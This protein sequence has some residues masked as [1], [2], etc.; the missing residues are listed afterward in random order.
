M[1]FWAWTF[2][3]S[4]MYEFLDTFILCWKNVNPSFLQVYHHIGA[5]LAMWWVVKCDCPLTWAW[6]IMNSFIHS[7][8]YFYY[9]AT[10]V[11]IRPPGKQIIT[12]SQIAQFIL[13]NL[14]ST[15]RYW[16]E[17]STYEQ[18]LCIWVNQAYTVGLII[19]FSNFSYHTYFKKSSK[20]S[21][22]KAA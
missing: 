8:M 19:L 18:K 12:L 20:P 22:S 17:D 5:V 9:A 6:V 4:K 21:K 15:G 14:F 13:G 7:I 1:M 16:P 10:T 11:G 3:L 2:Y